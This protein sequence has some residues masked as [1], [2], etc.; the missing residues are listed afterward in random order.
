MLP[1]PSVTCVENKQR[2][3]FTAS[4]DVGTVEYRVNTKT[5]LEFK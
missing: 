1:T 4:E 2:V 5:L 3:N